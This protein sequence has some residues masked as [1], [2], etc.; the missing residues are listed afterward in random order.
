MGEAVREHHRLLSPRSLEVED[1][2]DCAPSSDPSECCGTVRTWARNHPKAL[3][4]LFAIILICSTLALIFEL[5]P[6]V[7]WLDSA[8][9]YMQ[10]H[11]IA[12]G[13]CLFF[14]IFFGVSVFVPVAL[15]GMRVYV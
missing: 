15:L 3:W 9:E 6:I 5:L 13:A 10:T 7:R 4:T 2:S 14:I 12:S 8:K 11:H 1:V